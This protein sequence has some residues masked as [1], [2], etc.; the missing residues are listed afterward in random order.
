MRKIIVMLVMLVAVA[1]T[2]SAYTVMYSVKFVDED[3]DIRTEHYLVD[4]EF[5]KVEP[6]QDV[7]EEIRKESDFEAII[8]EDSN[9]SDLAIVNKLDKQG[10][11]IAM[12][13][14]LYSDTYMK[15]DGVWHRFD[16][17]DY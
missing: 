6:S 10:Y 16:C 14:A 11:F 4:T 12:S 15:I 9:L 1:F 8:D 7:Q 5:S 3:G 2:A 17:L 13:G